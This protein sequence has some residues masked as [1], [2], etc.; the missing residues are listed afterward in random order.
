MEDWANPDVSY[1]IE[2][3]TGK[4]RIKDFIFGTR[5]G[6]PRYYPTKFTTCVLDAKLM[7]KDVAHCAAASL[8]RSHYKHVNV[9]RLGYLK[10][11]MLNILW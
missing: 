1:Y 11:L 6:M 3:G 10:R 2:V 8:K 5:E 7:T 9:K 4:W